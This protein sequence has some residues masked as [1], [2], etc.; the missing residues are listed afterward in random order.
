MRKILLLLFVI[1]L[2]T[3]C[4]SN[5]KSVDVIINESIQR[6][7]NI[8][9]VKY[10]NNSKDLYEYYLPLYVGKVQSTQTSNIFKHS[11]YEIVMNL[12]VSAVISN[13]FY[14]NDQE[15]YKKNENAIYHNNGTYLDVEQNKINYALHLFV[16]DEEKY[17][18][19][20]NTNYFDFYSNVDLQHID[21]TIDTMFTIAKSA[22]VKANEIV[23]VYSSKPKP[24]LEVKKDE[25]FDVYISENGHL[26][27]L[28]TDDDF[29]GE[30]DDWNTENFDINEDYGSGDVYGN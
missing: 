5:A 21:D 12:D 14:V 4:S 26:D 27:E 19:Q 11:G 8:P 7:L 1:L 17:Y 25:L 2:L 3:G 24:K 29:N 13:L 9:A 15:K 30:N 16:D 28:I 6:N 22:R 10:R 23:S 18:V 20:L